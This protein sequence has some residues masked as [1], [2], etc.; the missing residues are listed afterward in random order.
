MLMDL[1]KSLSRRKQKIEIQKMFT[2]WTNLLHELPQGSILSPLLFD[3]FL[4]DLFLFI[5]N[6]N[7]VSYADDNTQF[8]MGSSEFEVINKINW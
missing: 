7:V 4:C 1:R 3:I 2:N 6:I 8:A 5:T